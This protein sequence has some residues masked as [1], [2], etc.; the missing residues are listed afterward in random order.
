MD[1]IEQMKAAFDSDD[2]TF[3]NRALRK[4][5]DELERLKA[6]EDACKVSLLVLTCARDG[7]T[8]HA[9]F[10]KDFDFAITACR[11]AIRTR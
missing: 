3:K 10:L 7:Q 1:T 4:A 2:V 6:A 8:W 9:N 5:H 11:G